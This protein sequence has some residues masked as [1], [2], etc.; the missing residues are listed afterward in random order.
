MIEELI[1]W[2]TLFEDKKIL[3]EETTKKYGDVLTAE[4]IKKFCDH[5][6]TG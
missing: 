3:K 6:F 4:Q 5:R 2:N 1:L